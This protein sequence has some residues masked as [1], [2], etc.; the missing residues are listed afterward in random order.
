MAAPDPV[1][2]A[3]AVGGRP[4]P[5]GARLRIVDHDEVVVARELLG[6]AAIDVFVERADLV[7]EL[8]RRPLQAVV[9]ALRD[10]EELAVG[11]HHL[12]LGLQADVVHERHQRVEDLGHAAAERGRIDVQDA[13]ALRAA[14][15]AP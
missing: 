10:V 13:L 9:E 14:P 15:R 4:G 8:D 2:L 6:V 1:R 12:P 11:R 5:Q 7:G 3:L